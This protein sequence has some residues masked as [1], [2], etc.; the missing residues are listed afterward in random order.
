MS[1]RD[2]KQAAA[3]QARLLQLFNGSPPAAEQPADEDA[4][5]DSPRRVPPRIQSVNFSGRTIYVFNGGARDFAFAPAWC[6]TDKELV[7]AAGGVSRVTFRAPPIFNPCP[8]LQRW[9]RPCM[10]TLTCGP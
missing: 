9:R 1:L 3:V 7:V 6:L 4:G 5:P 2:P 10:T 8:K